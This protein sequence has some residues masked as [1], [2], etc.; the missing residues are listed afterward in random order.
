MHALLRGS[1]AGHSDSRLCDVFQRRPYD[2]LL[3]AGKTGLTFPAD[4]ID[5]DCIGVGEAVDYSIQHKSPGYPTFDV[6]ITRPND[7]EY[8]VEAIEHVPHILKRGGRPANAGAKLMT[9]AA[10]RSAQ[11]VHEHLRR[12]IPFSSYSARKKSHQAAQLMRVPV[13][14][15]EVSAAASW[16]QQRRQ[17]QRAVCQLG[18]QRRHTLQS[19]RHFE[20]SLHGADFVGDYNDVYD[21]AVAFASCCSCPPRCFGSAPS[22]A[23]GR[24]WQGMSSRGSTYTA[25]SAA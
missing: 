24:Q 11:A 23:S 21:A 9:T 2:F 19:C 7:D 3:T 18:P 8:A 20:L 5:C 4:E 25:W 6:L 12:K 22:A 16:Q 14:A 1:E 15:I 10:L 17:N 13:A